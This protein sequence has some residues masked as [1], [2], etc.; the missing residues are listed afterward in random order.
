[1]PP[2]A[3]ADKTTA[4][5]RPDSSHFIR[6][7]TDMADHTSVV[8]GGA[9]YTDKG[10]KLVDKGVRIDSRLYDRLV[11]HRLRDPIDSEL[12]VEDLVDAKVLAEQ[13]RAKCTSID[14]MRRLAQAVGGVDKLL[15]P[16]YAVKLTRQVAF[17]LTVMQQQRPELYS[18]DLQM[19][20]VAIYLG[21]QSG[22]SE[23]DCA[24]AA[25][26]G[27]LHD[28]GMLFIDPVWMNP[29][30]QLSDMERRHFSAHPITAMLVVRSAQA[31]PESVERAVLEHHECM[32]GSGYPRGVRGEHISPLGQ[33]LI[34]AEV[35][36]AFFGKFQD[37]PSQRL[38]LML[39]MNHRR[40]PEHLVRLILPLL[41]DELTPG[42]PLLPLQEEVVHN[43]AALSAAFAL[44][45]TLREQLPEHW[46]LLPEGP[47]GIFVDERLAALRRQLA[48]VGAGPG[49]HDDLM[50]LLQ[51][52]LPSMTEFVLVNREALWQLRSV[53][54]AC[55]HRWPK[56]G[57][58]ENVVDRA[59]FAWCEACAPLQ[60]SPEATSD[61]EPA[62]ARV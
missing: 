30:Y 12:I 49:Q 5:E 62:P 28:V 13:A 47:P 36:S 9:I 16:L 2:P 34:V 1:M 10:V 38:S 8:T 58:T 32:D 24:S 61:A 48:D 44:W 3:L 17:K 14:L 19:T 54:H 43:V 53:V 15:A 33:V 45:E 21:L 59:V 27:L 26:A 60:P 35:V 37:M 6:A 25:A 50:A 29:A 51:S 31:Y 23:Q 55:L 46:G 39:R 56:L 20:L 57:Q 42:I 11:L 52:D 22:L 18:H 7:V 40:Y 41:Y 4:G